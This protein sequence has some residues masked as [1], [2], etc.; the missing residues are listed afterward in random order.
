MGIVLKYE[1]SFQTCVPDFSLTAEVILIDS[2][3]ILC[4]QYLLILKTK[5][6]IWE[7]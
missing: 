7:N 2:R 5:D 4:S 6:K 3:K 1:M